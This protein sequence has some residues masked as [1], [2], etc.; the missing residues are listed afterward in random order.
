MSYAV[1]VCRERCLGACV[2]PHNH[3]PS[4]VFPHGMGTHGALKSTYHL[5]GLAEEIPCTPRGL[6]HRNID[7]VRL[8]YSLDISASVGSMI[9]HSLS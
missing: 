8:P 5:S 1:P 6:Y 3:L 7:P 9:C 2:I 4:Q